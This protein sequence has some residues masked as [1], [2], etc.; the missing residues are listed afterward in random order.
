M[1]KHLA[2]KAI[3]VF[4]AAGVA[5]AT[6]ACGSTSS[7]TTTTT[8][9]T[10]GSTTTSAPS[11]VTTLKVALVAPS[12]ANDLAFTESM[13]NA[14]ESLKTSEHLQI[15]VSV[16]EFVVSD[17]ANI[18]REYASQGYNLVI[19]HGS[20]YGST[21]EQL[22][23][24]FPHT[25]FAWGTAGST[26]GQANIFAYEAASN[27]GGYVQG[28]MAALL[29]KHHVLGVIG[30]IATGDAKLYVDGFVAGAKAA[31]AAN[32]FSV[33]ANPVYTGSFS[34][35]SL[36]AT[37]ARTFVSDGADILTGS[38]QSV[39]GAIGV[40]RSDNLAWFSTQW[41]QASVAP[42]N[43]VS[44]QIY[45]WVP[46][47]TQMITAIRSGKL[48]GATYVIG[49]GNG[50]EMI[51]FNPSFALPASIKAEAQKLITG[52]TDGSITPPQ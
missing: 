30:P 44:S 3:L 31:A 24:Q 47:L 40:A 38:S 32:H 11:G 9:A 21:I 6:A 43:V 39:V 26:F 17:A 5:L 50:G 20:Q 41:S 48:G 33:T 45:N 13:Y 16:N 28:Y 37:A 36:M 49:L 15:A 2:R 19:A 22:A 29:S 46:I 34:D 1:R 12:A 42:K 23:P 10:G 8:V 51:Q 52:I 18:I 25:S 4:V 14:L 7:G 27:E 35:D